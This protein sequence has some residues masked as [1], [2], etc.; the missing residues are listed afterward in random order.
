MSMKP[1]CERFAARLAELD[2]AGGLEPA[3]DAFLTAHRNSCRDCQRLASALEV[4]AARPDDA[5]HFP[6]DELSRRRLVDAVLA[7]AAEPTEERAGPA[8]GRWLAIAA[9]VL[10]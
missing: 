10:L 9:G 7:G 4:I 5:D 6:L 2:E 8:R 3:Q 1:E